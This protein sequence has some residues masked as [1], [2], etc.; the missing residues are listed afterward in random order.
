[1]VNCSKFQTVFTLML[2]LHSPFLINIY[3]L[4]RQPNSGL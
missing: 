1:M 3:Q 2:N 4:C